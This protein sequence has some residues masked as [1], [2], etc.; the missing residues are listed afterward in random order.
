M[1]APTPT[2][3]TSCPKRSAA[4]GVATSDGTPKSMSPPPPSSAGGLSSFSCLAAPQQHGE[5]NRCCTNAGRRCD[6]EASGIRAK[7]EVDGSSSTKSVNTWR[8]AKFI[9]RDQL[10]LRRQARHLK[11]AGND[12]ACSLR[13]TT[14]KHQRAEM[15]G[16]EKKMRP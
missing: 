8:R 3:S 12:S 5:V 1:M 4:R 15:K 7:A 11:I 2:K 9:S 16:G 14:G 10:T 6:A 13:A